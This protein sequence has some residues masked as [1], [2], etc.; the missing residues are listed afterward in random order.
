MAT[1]TTTSSPNPVIRPFR[2]SQD[3]AAPFGE[4]LFA[5]SFTIPLKDALNE[6]FVVISCVMPPNYVYRLLALEVYMASVGTGEGADREPLAAVT[7]TENQVVTRRIPCQ[8]IFN[9]GLAGWAYKQAPDT[10]TNDYA[11]YYLP[12]G[13]EGALPDL[14]GQLINASQGSSILLW[15]SVDSSNDDSAATFVQFRFLLSVYTVEQYN[16]APINTPRWDV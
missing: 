4:L 14:S 11:W 1:I 9:N 3:P 7:I 12:G 5:S 10:V 2:E 6:S 16:S 13:R 15:E 8:N